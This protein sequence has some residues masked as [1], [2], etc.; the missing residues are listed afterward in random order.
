MKVGVNVLD[1]NGQL[2]NMDI[3]LDELGNHW[4]NLN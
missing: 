1:V 4:N 2:K 3:I